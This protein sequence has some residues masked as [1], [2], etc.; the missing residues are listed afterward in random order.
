MRLGQLAGI[1]IIGLTGGIACGKSTVANMFRDHGIPVIDADAIA[2]L[3]VEPSQ[4][5]F[6]EIRREF[7]ET[8]IDPNGQLDRK[9]L[10]ER[11]FR[12][13]EARKR[14]ETITH[15]RIL[16]EAQ[17][18][19]RALAAQNHELGIYEA[20]L[21]VETGSYAALDGL[22]VV[23]AT[24]SQQIARLLAR[25]GFSEAEAKERIA[26]QLP[27]EEKTRIADYIVDNSGDLRATRQQVDAVVAQLRG[28]QSRS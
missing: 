27:L 7:G 12:D 11:V 24:K 13:P 26:A 1:R 22:V 3:V 19:M 16:E 4:P 5:A 14:L 8:V 10:G 18:R 17:K 15:P 20:A 25:D 21:L 23:T 9:R 6:L 28:S 2:R